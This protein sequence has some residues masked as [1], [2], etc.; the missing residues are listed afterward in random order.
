MNNYML[1]NL[2]IAIMGIVLLILIFLKINTLVRVRNNN[3][4]KVDKGLSEILDEITEEVNILNED[5][6]ER[7]IEEIT[8]INNE[9]VNSY[10]EVTNSV[11]IMN[12]NF[13]I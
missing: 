11:V 9:D 7:V 5:T 3:L 1:V 8:D 12:S 13:I 2:L 6:A 4:N 10:F